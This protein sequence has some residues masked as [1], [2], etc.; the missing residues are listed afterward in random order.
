[1]SFV[2]LPHCPLESETP[3]VVRPRFNHQNTQDRLREATRRPSPFSMFSNIRKDRKSVFREVGLVSE[4]GGAMPD[5]DEK[6]AV[7]AEARLA[8]LDSKS[9]G[10]GYTADHAHVEDKD[11]KA[12]TYEVV[13]TQDSGQRDSN[14]TIQAEPS[15]PQSLTSKTPWYAKIATGKR[16]RVR[17]GSST[18]PTSFQGLS[19]ATMVVLA[20]A[21]VIPFSGRSSQDTVGL[22]D[23]GP[24][25]KKAK[26]PTDV[27]ARWAMQS[28]LLC[29][30]SR[31]TVLLTVYQNWD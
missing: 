30:I 17:T 10:S 8:P 1:M 13:A 31:G 27:C 11:G 29:E 9:A 4:D 26:S 28:E 23:A 16:P 6:H 22:A 5:L 14:Y 20:L 24:I 3:R 7:K 18:P 2:K 19:R 15:S 12:G 25:I 21:L